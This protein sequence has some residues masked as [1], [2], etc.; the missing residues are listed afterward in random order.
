[1]TAFSIALLTSIDAFLGLRQRA[2]DLG[3]QVLEVDVG[4]VR[5]HRAEA[6]AER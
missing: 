3:E 2:R 1:V 4:G 5:A 6:A